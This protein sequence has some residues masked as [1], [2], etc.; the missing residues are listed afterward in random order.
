MLPSRI[1]LLISLTAVLSP[2]GFAGQ[3]PTLDQ[4]LEKLA[5]TLEAARI[6][7]HVPGMSI[8]I[9]KD[10]Q[11]IWTHGFGIADVEAKTP[12][13]EHTIYG[14]GSTT[15]AFTAN[16]VG[17]LI[18]D[19]KTNWDMPVTQYLPYFDLDLKTDDEN[20]ECTLRDL[21]SHRHGFA[22]MGLLWFSG[23][24][25]RDKIL[26]TAVNAEPIDEFRAGFHYCNVTYLAAGEAAGI[27]N[28]TSWDEMMVSRIFK[29]LDMVS[30]IVHTP[31]PEADPA[32]ALGYNW[33]EF[34]EQFERAPA[35]NMN[36]IAPA[37]GVYSNVLDM[38]QWIRFQ[39]SEGEID[40]KRLVSSEVIQETW[41]PQIEIGGG[42]SYGLGW[43]LREVD[44]RK[45]VEH[46]GM[47]PGF[48]AQVSLMPEE[49]LGYVLLMNQGISPLA[50][51]SVEWIFNA[52][53]EQWPDENEIVVD[54]NINFEDF[55]GTY[56]A[57][58][59]KFQD[60]PF[61]IRI[62]DDGLELNVPSQRSFALNNPDS[63]GLWAFEL[64]DQIALSFKRNPQGEVVGLVMH[65]S[66]FSFQVPRKG[67][68]EVA[69]APSD[70]LDQYLGG[71]IRKQGG[72]KV[73]IVINR[74]RLAMNDKGTLLDFEAP[75]K[76]GYASL[77]D[78]P[79][80]GA[81]FKR[82]PEGAV[83]SFV[84]HGGAGDRLFVRT[85]EGSTAK[86]PTIEEIHELRNT[87]GRVAA[88]QKAGGMKATGKLWVA[89]S[90]LSGTFTSYTQGKHQYA[91]HMDFK[92]HGH[93]DIVTNSNGAWYFDSMRGYITLK[94]DEQIQAML[95][96][97]GAIEGDWDEYF[98]S[99]QVI[100]TDM[101]DDRPAYVVRL[102]KGELPSRTYRIDA[103]F[104]DVVQI[105]M[106]EKNGQT[107]VPVTISYSEF[108]VIAGFR[109]PMR[110]VSEIPGSGFTIITIEEIES[111]LELAE[112]V[113][114]LD[115]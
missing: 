59:A 83:E 88:A 98:D 77:R 68:E 15:K 12:A 101:V 21:L 51:A 16:L 56:I 48:S 49:N 91:N 46:G 96:A 67:H 80:W 31:D 29:P 85:V 69:V 95:K 35:L 61:E 6:K 50:E 20:A 42:V 36:G 66:G 11:I 115:E 24:V 97:P 17:M 45:V 57:N 8:A 111:G 5:E 99:I 39:L 93:V 108:K 38:A 43:M 2:L 105:N 113:F 104:G 27:A 70:E 89:Q 63:D 103:E 74:G 110:I 78:R 28:G 109:T 87:S 107:S 9:V 73:Q 75:D 82:D 33:N 13:N 34:D 37:G 23:D 18:D 114:M 4:R 30:T 47:I 64:T 40:G 32:V 58:F 100:G 94:G 52:L 86:I 92:E 54:Q 25:S 112:E 1:P 62:V 26:H 76:H 3:E 41:M 84:F 60:E 22:R 14:I 7:A 10:D 106:I 44:G 55:T 65:Q 71:Y 19:G 90:G 81:T 102:K 79:D 53:L 72:K